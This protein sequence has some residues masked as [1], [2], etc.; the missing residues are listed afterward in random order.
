MTILDQIKDLEK[1]RQKLLAT[2]KAE[3]LK[4]A[5]DA[6]ADLQALGF[7]YTLTEKGTTVPP[8]PRRKGVRTEVLELIRQFPLGIKRADILKQLNTAN[9]KTAEQ[10]ISNAL[11]ALKKDET[12]T[13]NAGLYTAKL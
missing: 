6:I 10:S 1:Q 7:T 13:A 5:E 4:R 12:I 8:S 9:S 3:A 11:A 2:G